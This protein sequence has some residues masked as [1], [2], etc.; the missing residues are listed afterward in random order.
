MTSDPANTPLPAA[1]EPRP[2]AGSASGSGPSAG[3]PS[4]AE[5]LALRQSFIGY[6]TATLSEAEAESFELRLLEDDEFAGDIDLIEQDLLEE[7]AA[8]TLAQSLAAALPDA[9][10]RSTVE[11]RIGAWIEASPARREHV[12]V[13]RLL[14]DQQ[15][16]RQ[17][18]HA[19]AHPASPAAQGKLQLLRRNNPWLWLGA[20]SAACLLAGAMLTGIV[21]RHTHPGTATMPN[22][23]MPTAAGPSLASPAATPS[24]NPA[25]ARSPDVI[26]LSAERLRG[27]APSQSA[28]YT[29][30]PDAPIRLQ[31]LLPR[32]STA[33][34]SAHAYTLSVRPA[35]CQA[36]LARFSGLTARQE[37]GTLYLEASLA[38][39]ALKPGSYVVTVT[40]PG[41]AVD[42]PLEVVFF[43]T[44]SKR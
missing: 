41:A 9:S 25:A 15:S 18:A 38:A 34:V 29:L 32:A 30:H 31:V 13:T 22:A 33:S 23:S 27:P 43:K 36:V 14:L 35:N 21:L 12:R 1:P 11:G 5:D 8:G 17:P 6:I 44:G 37:S 7:Y 39:D 24:T 3:S 4:L 42:M 16:A 10:T 20:A 28:A 19:A 40:S 2:G 26:L